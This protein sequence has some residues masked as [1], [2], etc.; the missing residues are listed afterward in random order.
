MLNT[1][2]TFAIYIAGL[3]FQWLKRR[4]GSRR[5]KT[6]YRAKAELLYDC[7]DASAFYR[8]PVAHDD[9]SRMNVPFKLRD[10]ALDEAFLEGAQEAGLVQLKGHRVGRRNARLD[11]QRDADRRRAGAGRPT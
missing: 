11:L 4:A 3:V 9:R 6:Q 1:P 10:P 8:N 2:P 7:I 5:S